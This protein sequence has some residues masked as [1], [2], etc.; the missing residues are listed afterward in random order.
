MADWTDLKGY[1]NADD[2]KDALVSSCWEQAETLVGAFVGT[3]SLP[4]PARDLA[5]TVVGADLYN[6][7]NAPNGIAQFADF[8]G[9]AVR[10]ARDPLLPAY[11]ILGRFMVIGL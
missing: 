7:R 4:A 6:R 5:I 9:N 11:P 8:E 1:V 2:S 10:I 3:T